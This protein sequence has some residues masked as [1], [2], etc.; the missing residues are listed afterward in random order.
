MSERMIE[1]VRKLLALS[2]SSNPHEAS[3]AAE[4]ARELV[5]K[6]KLA[7]ADLEMRE[8]GAAIE[9]HDYSQNV[10]GWQRDLGF[11]LARSFFCRAIHTP[12]GKDTGGRSWLHLVGKPEDI[13]TVL[14]LFGFLRVE[15]KRLSKIAYTTY[16]RN[17]IKFGGLGTGPKL[18]QATEWK[19]DFHNGAVFVIDGR[20]HAMTRKFTCDSSIARAIVRVSDD[21]INRKIEETFKGLRPTT[22]GE[23]ITSLSGWTEGNK[24]GSSIKLSTGEKTLPKGTP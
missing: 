22:M 24:A 5:E 21:A 13:E 8:E 2:R 9:S 4:K 19:R 1:R 23:P 12:R 11:V 15:L 7:Q 14:A 16:R 17:F 6:Y 10:V 20:L 3:A 18:V